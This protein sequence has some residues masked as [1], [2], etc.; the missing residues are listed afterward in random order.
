MPPS[1]ARPI[2][3]PRRRIPSGQRES[4]GMKHYFLRLLPPRPW[5]HPGAMTADE[6]AIMQAHAAYWRGLLEAGKAVAFGP[7]ADPAGL[8]DVGL[9]AL[10]EGED[11]HIIARADPALR[12]GT[13]FRT[14]ISPMLALVHNERETRA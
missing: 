12:A 9:L 3:K 14:E 8:Y 6:A 4:V 10:D 11:P 7:V 5:A 13:G 1:A 2:L